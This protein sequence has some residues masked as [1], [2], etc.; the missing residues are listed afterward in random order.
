MRIAAV[1]YLNTLPMLA[2]LE[3]SEVRSEIELHLQDPASCARMLQDGEVDVALCPVGALLDVDDFEIV[4]H[5]GIGCNGRVR[6]VAV[7][8]DSPFNELESIRLYPESRTSNILV[9]VLDRHHWKQGFRFLQDGAPEES[10]CGQ[11]AIGD[12][13]FEYESKFQHIEDLGTAWKQMSGLPFV[14]AV[15][16][17]LK[18]V[19]PEL[20]RRIDHAFADGIDHIEQIEIPESM[21]H[22]GVDH[23]L[24]ENIRYEINDEATKGLRKFIDLARSLE[25]LPQNA[26]R[27]SSGQPIS[28]HSSDDQLTAAG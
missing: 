21:A 12:R 25:K 7:Y 22:I 6:T 20:W 13:C 3:R 5:F 18:P 24:K 17:S 10:R 15:W 8:S 26:V 23:Y 11:L 27:T 19:D 2:G 1:K 16:V 14:F 4:S 9:Q 28:A